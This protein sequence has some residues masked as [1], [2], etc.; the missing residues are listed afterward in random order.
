MKRSV[1][2]PLVIVLLAVAGG[3]AMAQQH[4]ATRLGNPETRFAPP[5][6]SQEELRSRFA[7]EKLR[8]DIESILR[9]AR[10]D[11]DVGDLY[12]AAAA[13]T[14]FE[15]K[16]PRGTRMP[17]MSSRHSGNPITLLD[18]L[19]DGPEPIQAYAF[20][21]FSKGRLYRCITP[22]PCS[23]FFLVDMG[24]P[25]LALACSAPG[26][27][28]LGKPVE[29]CLNVANVGGAVEPM[30]VVS[31][32]APPGAVLEEA[33]PASSGTADTVVWRLANFAPK[34]T[35]TLC[36]RFKITAPGG[37]AFKAAARGIVARGAETACESRVGG[38]PA[39]LIDAVDLDDPVEEGKE[40]TYEIKVT[41][42]GS[43]PVTNLRLEFNLP[44]NEQFVS[45]SG[46]TAV[47]GQDHAAKTEPIASFASKAVGTW[48]VVVK[49]LKAGDV[50][51]QVNLFAD[52]FE[53][54]IFEEES[55]HLYR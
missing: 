29:V 25:E 7:D 33:T 46:D 37:L 41:N 27:V 39:L 8:P 35:N 47:S 9:Q 43:I 45:G 52:E 6:N 55:T 11:G 4:R 5:I 15:M 10:W 22:R 26:E 40:V 19:W 34:S 31:L 13:A 1:R 14:V 12:K 24:A 53:R 38:I 23:N 36:A 44:E 50:R 21:F 32:P 20:D 48:R 3:I 51:F 49:A 17:Y 42:Q 30:A 54:P 2:L 16:L 18:V 28:T